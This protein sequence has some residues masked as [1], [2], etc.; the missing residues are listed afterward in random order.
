M[1]IV[2][3]SPNWFGGVQH[4]TANAF[5]NKGVQVVDFFYNHQ[6]SP[7]FSLSRSKETPKTVK[8]I[9]I[10]PIIKKMIP[11]AEPMRA[12]LSAG[13]VEK[14]IEKINSKLLKTV[15]KEK[16]DLVMVI[17]GEILFLETIKKIRNTYNTTVIAWWLDS[18]FRLERSYHDLLETLTFYNHVFIFDKHYLDA[19]KETG[20]KDVSFLPNCVDDTIF[21]KNQV[22]QVD[23]ENYGGQLAY[24]GAGYPRRILIL[25]QLLEFEPRIW[26]SG[27]STFLSANHRKMFNKY[28]NERILTPYEAV[29]IYN[30]TD[31][32][33]NFHRPQCVHGT[34]QKVYEIAACGGFQ[35]VHSVGALKEQ[36]SIGNEMICY[37][38][39]D[40]LKNKIF[41]Y[42]YN[43][44]ERREIAE[45]AYKKVKANHTY[46]HR[47]EKLLEVVE[48]I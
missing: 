31:I 36:F 34:N 35:L 16:P 40:D 29:K 27:Y 38:D 18:P 8:G 2:L 4:Y 17:K 26:G 44:K 3:V 12:A 42:L 30:S 11:L 28:L 20:L 13:R 5:R 48:T 9:N 45:N 32:L 41:Y 1:K 37:T 10:K 19:L 47:I 6:N 7:A 22:D 39:L 23:K 33:L 14:N 15:Q 46:T 21:K 24:L 25:K 43:G